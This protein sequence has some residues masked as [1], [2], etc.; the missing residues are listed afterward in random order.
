MRKGSDSH[1]ASDLQILDNVL[2]CKMQSL[3]RF[4]FLL[5]TREQTSLTSVV[6]TY[7]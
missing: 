3:A 4:A 1:A 6:L 7:I 2:L 5:V